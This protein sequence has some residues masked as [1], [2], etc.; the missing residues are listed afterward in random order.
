ML[1]Q[2]GIHDYKHKDFKIEQLVEFL[3]PFARKEPK[4]E[5]DEVRENKE[6]QQ[7][8]N[9]G[10]KAN[11]IEV[12][13][14]NFKKEILNS[15]EAQMVLFT[16][17]PKNSAIEAEVKYFNKLIRAFRGVVN[18]AVFRIDPN[19]A[20]HAALVKKYKVG[21]LKNDKPK[22]RSYPNGETGDAK[23]SGS[24]EI[25]FNKDSKDFSNVEEEVEENYKH[26]VNDILSDQ[27]NNFIVR[28]AKDEQKNVIYYMYRSDQ[29]ISLDF[30]ATSQHPLFAEDCVFLS[31]IDP[32]PKFFDG[33]DKNY[34]PV[35]GVV[36]KLDSN[37]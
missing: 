1:A 8:A 17:L 13:D 15:H 19:S 30:K 37:F 18:F 27:F 7:D 36:K 28:H 25:F 26:N 3:E 31:L 11:F 16:T 4:P 5:S 2:Y 34:L 14:A 29:K 22:L 21:S 9:D 33:M 35:I 10:N 12:T 24:Y 6:Q 23:M 20:N 32:D